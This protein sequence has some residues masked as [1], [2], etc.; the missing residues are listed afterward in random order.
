MAELEGNRLTVPDE[1]TQR[2]Q[3]KPDYRVNILER[4]VWNVVVQEDRETQ[5]FPWRV[6]VSAEGI[7][8]TKRTQIARGRTLVDALRCFGLPFQR[9]IYRQSGIDDILVQSGI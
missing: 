8:G 6:Y 3:E 5:V 2:L 9:E 4:G 7:D 1:I